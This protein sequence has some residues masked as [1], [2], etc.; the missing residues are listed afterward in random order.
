MDKKWKVTLECVVTAHERHEAWKIAE[1]KIS[2]KY[3]GLIQVMRV[4]LEPVDDPASW[5]A[6]NDLK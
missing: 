3:D 1:E 5:V 2:N 6:I 4:A